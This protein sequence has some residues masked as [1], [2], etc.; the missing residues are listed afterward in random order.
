L[1]EEEEE[2]IPSYEDIGGESSE[3]GYKGHPEASF[4]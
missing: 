4:S 2:E 3:D 1:E